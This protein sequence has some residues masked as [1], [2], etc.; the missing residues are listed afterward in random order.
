M[1]VC[2]CGSTMWD[3]EMPSCGQW[4]C[5][6]RWWAMVGLPVAL[7]IVGLLALGLWLRPEVPCAFGCRP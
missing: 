5:L 2:H 7:V 1:P 3:G 6:L 4:R